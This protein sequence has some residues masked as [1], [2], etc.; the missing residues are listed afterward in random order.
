[1]EEQRNAK[2]VPTFCCKSALRFVRFK[3][4]PLTTDVK[5]SLWARF[6]SLAKSATNVFAQTNFSKYIFNP[7]I[8]YGYDC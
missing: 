3:K 5:I 7:E 4:V 2:D 1:M 6:C 8:C